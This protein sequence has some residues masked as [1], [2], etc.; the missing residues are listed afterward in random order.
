MSRQIIIN[1]WYTIVFFFLGKKWVIRQLLS[2]ISKKEKK[3][4]GF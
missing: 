4:K 1:K 2:N 3:K